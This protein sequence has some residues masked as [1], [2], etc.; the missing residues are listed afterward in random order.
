M[1]K[2]KNKEETKV[3]L[4]KITTIETKKETAEELRLRTIIE[5]RTGKKYE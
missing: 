5:S 4:K 1:A 3:S 2:K